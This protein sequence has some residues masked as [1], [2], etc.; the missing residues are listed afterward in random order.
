MTGVQ[1]SALPI[2]GMEILLKDKIDRYI[3]SAELFSRV[4]KIKDA[5]EMFIRASR[6]TSNEQKAKIRLARKNIYLIAARELENKKKRASS[7]KFYEKLIKMNLDEIEK[8][9]IKE[10]L[11]TAYK[12]LGLFRE[13]RLIEEIGRASCR[14]RV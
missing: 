4:G 1:T 14:E 9:E 10:K 6:D 8:S 11:L 3:T 2:S 12:A 7:V 5:D 13:A